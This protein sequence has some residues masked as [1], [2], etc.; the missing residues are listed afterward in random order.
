MDQNEIC[1]S[2]RDAKDKAMQIHVLA[3][4]TL[5]DDE[6]II[7]I[8]KDN[9]LFVKESQCRKCGDRYKRF[10]SPYCEKCA[11]KI[12]KAKEHEDKRKKWVLYA[13]EKNEVK[14]AEY[15]RKADELRDENI[16]L[17]EW[18]V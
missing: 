1:K 16:K 11:E 17:M 6:T 14:R 5:S 18:L 7:E 13:V 15:L 3:D 4:L 8:L 10:L 12:R 2:F 9:N